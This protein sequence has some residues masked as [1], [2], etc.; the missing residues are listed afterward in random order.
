MYTG[1]VPCSISDTQKT[2]ASEVWNLI[3]PDQGGTDTFSVPLSP[4]GGNNPTAWGTLTMLERECYDALAGTLQPDGVTRVPLTNAQFDAFLA[5]RHAKF[6]D[7]PIPSNAG[8]F[9]P[10][11]KIGVEYQEFDGFLSEHGLQ[12]VALPEVL[13]K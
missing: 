6:P 1:P 8:S 13:R 7:R 5:M 11:F 3:D 12:R 9:R 10:Q 2:K 4:S